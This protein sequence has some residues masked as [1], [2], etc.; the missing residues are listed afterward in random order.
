MAWFNALLACL[1]LGLG[2]LHLV[3]LATARRD[4]RPVAGEA[5]HAVMGFGMAAM[6]SPVGDPVPA[7]VWIAAFGLSAAWFAAVALRTGPA[8]D[9]A[10]HH[11][12]CGVAMLFMLSF[13]LGER[14]S[15]GAHAHHAAAGPAAWTSIVATVLAGYFAWHVMRC[16]DRFAAARRARTAL[17]EPVPAGMSAEI[18]PPMVDMA[19]C[20]HGGVVVEG[21]L[22]ALRAPQAAAVAHLVMATSMAVMLLGM[23]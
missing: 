8:S 17:T 7:A 20:G 13:G 9:D 5:S 15:G 4:G 11:V 10:G 6:F 21:R 12:V 14:A 23:I 1:S 16:G 2:L 22:A 19:S 3:R 18:A